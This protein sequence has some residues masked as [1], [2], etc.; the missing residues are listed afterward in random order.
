LAA[1]SVKGTYLD[2]G[3]DIDAADKLVKTIRKLAR[4]TFG[5]EVLGDLGFFGGLF[6]LKGYQEPVLVSSADGVGTK[7]KIACALNQ[8]DTIGIDL[9]NH[10]INDIFTCGAKPL[11]FQDYI[12]MAKL[13]PSILENI[14]QGMTSALNEVGCALI[15]GETAE[16][17]GLY[18][19]GEYD[20]VGFIVGIVEKSKLING[21]SIEAGD[22]IIGLPSSGL[23]TN[24]YSLVRKIFNIDED[25]SCLNRIY[26]ELG[27]NLGE[28]LLEPHLCYY[29]ILKSMLPMIKG[30]SPYHRWGVFPAIYPAY[31]LMD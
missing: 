21:N 5:P 18:P 10:C 2:A 20:F 8:H 9:A 19:E 26:P 22:G 6:E 14:V 17:P 31:Y 23:H 11:F 27:R 3:V 1:K 4:T 25:P 13:V 16:M 7:L 30:H 28:E 15:G 29:P 12:A 24:G